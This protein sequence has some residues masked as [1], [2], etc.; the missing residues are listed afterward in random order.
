MK[1][2]IAIA[3]ALCMLLS[4]MVFVSADEPATEV[5]KQV[6]RV[7]ADSEAD[8]LYRNTAK[9]NDTRRYA[10]AT[11]EMVYKYTVENH[12]KVTR[13][14]WSAKVGAQLLLQVSQDDT[15]WTDF[16][17]YEYDTSKPDNQGHPAQH[18]QFDLT[19]YVD[20]EENPDI[21]IRVAD[22]ETSKGWGGAVHKDTDVVLMV[23][24]VP[25]TNEEADAIEATS[26]E[27]SMSLLTCTT[28]FGAFQQNVENKVAGASSLMMNVGSGQ[29]PF[30]VFHPPINGMGYDAVEFELYVSDLALFDVK[31]SNTQLELTSSGICDKEEIGW[32]LATIKECIVGEPRVGWNHVVLYISEATANG[33]LPF[34]IS[35]INFFRFFMV[36][37]EGGNVDITVGIDNVRLTEAG[38]ERDA[39]IA[40]ENAAAANKVVEVINKIG[41]VSINSEKKIQRAEEAYAELTEDQK[42]L[43]TNYE[44][45]TAAREAY[46]ALVKQEEENAKQEETKTEE[47]SEQENEDEKTDAPAQTPDDEQKGGISPIVIVVIVVAVALVAAALVIVLVKK[48]K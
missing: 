34:D 44:A 35:R 9:T 1:K 32:D 3:M 8:Y 11:N 21:Y 14:V 12:H 30:Y 29:A 10:D 37:P 42:A 25:L 22:C 20:L 18:M 2:L 27:R 47:G 39:K 23:E 41:T 33:D 46:D 13:V 28:P 38:A 4:C 5:E 31:F 40:E 45:L 19:E 43:V 16:F 26:D 15:N 24:Y 36:E 7:M 6:F 17:V 48:K